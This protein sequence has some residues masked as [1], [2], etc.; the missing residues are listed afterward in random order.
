[1]SVN[2]RQRIT[3]LVKLPSKIDPVKLPQGVLLI[4]KLYADAVT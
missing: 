1:M 3:P 4:V 2:L